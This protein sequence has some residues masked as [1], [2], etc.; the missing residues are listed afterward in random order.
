MINRL[1]RNSV[2]NSAFNTVT[3]SVINSAFTSALTLAALSV[4]TAGAS[5]LSG[6]IGATGEGDVTARIGIVSEWQSRWYETGVGSLTGY[7]DIAYTYWDSGALYSAAHSV[8]FSPVLV[9][10]FSNRYRFTPFIEAGVGATLFSKTRVGEH[11][12]GSAFNFENRLGFGLKLPG[13][14]R[15]GIRAIHYSN[16]GLKTPNDGI[17]SYALFYSKAF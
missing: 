1:A 3:H 4:S 6:A 17:E 10:E 15:I 12:L 16:A 7:W 13:E 11:N 14:Q 2:F 8:S 9:Y 5:G